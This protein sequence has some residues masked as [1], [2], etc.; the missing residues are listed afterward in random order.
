M[1]SRRLF[2]PHFSTALL[3]LIAILGIMPVTAH[4]Q[5]EDVSTAED[6]AIAFFKTA[7]TNPDFDLW[8]KSSREYKVAPPVR[9]EEVL[10][11]EKQRLM[12]KW[13]AY[14]TKEGVLNIEAMVSVELKAIPHKDGSEEYWM[15][16]VF[17]QKGATYFPYKFYKYD[18]AV[19]PQQIE[20]LMIQPLQREQYILIR[21]NLPD[22]G[23]ASAFISM[24]L[25]P[26]KAYIQQP[27][28]IDNREQ[29]ALMCEVATMSLQSM[30]GHQPMW[31][32]S[33]DWYVSP[34]TEELRDLYQKP[35]ERAPGSAPDNR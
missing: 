2:Y 32:Y 3:F 34:V 13:Q 14:D 7:D 18:F 10:F 11:N 22:T 8:A 20:S 29:W 16:V 33:A 21:N 35:E 26:E 28:V 17:P 1:I 9:V 19:I 15:Y 23:T 12:K 31:N 30:N 27:Y 25:K 24:Q 5:P 4:A 6:V